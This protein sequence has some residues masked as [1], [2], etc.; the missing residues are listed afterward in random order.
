MIEAVGEGMRTDDA[1][2][3]HGLTESAALRLQGVAGVL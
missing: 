1:K 2:E 3:T